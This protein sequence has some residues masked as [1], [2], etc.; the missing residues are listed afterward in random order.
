MGS[1]I[2]TERSRRTTLADF[3]MLARRV[4]PFSR[5]IASARELVQAAA[6]LLD[7]KVAI[8][9][10][11]REGAPARVVVAIEPEKMR[12]KAEEA[13]ESLTAWYV[14]NPE[15]EG[16][17][18]GLEG[19]VYPGEIELAGKSYCNGLVA[20]SRLW[21]REP[22]ELPAHE[23]LLLGVGGSR[24]ILP[25]SYWVWAVAELL[26][27]FRYRESIYALGK[28]EDY[29]KLL[30]GALGKPSIL[31]EEPWES[32]IARIPADQGEISRAMKCF[33][34]VYWT[35]YRLRNYYGSSGGAEEAPVPGDLEN[36]TAAEDCA[37]SVGTA[38]RWLKDHNC[39][40]PSEPRSNMEEAV[41]RLAERALGLL[42]A[43][44][45][46][47]CARLSS[48]RKEYVTPIECAEGSGGSPAGLSNEPIKIAAVV[49][50]HCSRHLMHELSSH[51]RRR[52]AAP[53]R[54]EAGQQADMTSQEIADDQ[55]PQPNSLD[56]LATEVLDLAANLTVEVLTERHPTKSPGEAEGR[57][58]EGEVSREVLRLVLVE[59]V[60][61]ATK[62]RRHF[63]LHPT[64]GQEAMD[65]THFELRREFWLSLA[66]Y[67]CWVAAL[68]QRRFGMTPNEESVSASEVLDALL[69]LVDRYV[70]IELEVDERFAVRQHL[71]RALSAEISLHLSRSFYRDHLVHAIDVF[72]L[73]MVVLRT[74][75]SWLGSK[76][77]PLATHLCAL[78]G[79]GGQL[80]CREA[81]WRHNWAIAAL[82][83]DVGY[84]ATDRADWPRG[85]APQE[86]FEFFRLRAASP[87][88]WLR[89]PMDSGS[90]GKNRRTTWEGFIH[91]LLAKLRKNHGEVL[92][93][94]P[95]C[96]ELDHRD[97]GALSMLRIAQLAVYIDSLDAGDGGKPARMVRQIAPALHAIYQ[98]SRPRARVSLAR[99]PL[100]CLLRLCDELQEDSRPQVDS[101]RLIKQLYL[102]I[103]DTPATGRGAFP[104]HDPLRGCR[105][106]NLQMNSPERNGG[107]GS[108]L[109]FELPAEQGSRFRAELYYRNP[110]SANY[111]PTLTLLS[112]AFALQHLDLAV[113]LDGMHAMEWEVRLTF[114]TPQEYGSWSE[115]DIY[116]LFVDEVRELPLLPMVDQ[117]RERRKAAGLMR[118]PHR[119][120][121][122][123]ECFAIVLRQR[124]RAQDRHGW[125]PMDPAEQLFEEFVGFKRRILAPPGV[126]GRPR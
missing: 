82:L 32:L 86:L 97:H 92:D 71:G 44:P 121:R 58:A 12:E 59:M 16:S 35:G 125:I 81:Q 99:E 26:R 56:D 52:S 57:F 87:R 70:H 107:G 105:I 34:A 53:C 11:E 64:G 100:S 113:E 111:D 89:P 118:L 68:I 18:E 106:E 48:F 8:L 108:R 15:V 65:L 40:P 17:T 69:H 75:I 45:L 21:S 24:E 13:I 79:G 22:D 63:R 61:N 67:C 46:L 19:F 38:H 39:L 50:E 42:T 80:L 120:G 4:A 102:D 51:G 123:E 126:A 96:S 93:W 14:P 5:R 30:S 7:A 43:R 109:I 85:G 73:G 98:H 95:K 23:L 28:A 77:E 110:S 103:L 91:H 101:E 10:R 41:I 33:A 37:K 20:C 119:P 29:A 116:A 31:M 66:R 112:K 3:E 62:L 36:S 55:P 124:A 72:L 78:S 27:G 76:R 25:D 54:G 74:E 122:H 1:G 88:A 117:N 94:L 6:A 9:L 115:Y 49:L 83:H 60:A 90:D 47:D 84:Q 104:A 2:M 114:P